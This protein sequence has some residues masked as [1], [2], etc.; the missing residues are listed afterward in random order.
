MDKIEALNAFWNSFDIPAIDEQSAYD[1][2]TLEQMQID[3][4]YITYE[5]AED[6]FDAPVAIG[7]DIWDKSTSWARVTR[8]AAQIGDALGRGGLIFP[9]E[10]G[11]IW[12]TR[13]S[14]FSQR[15]SAEND[16]NVRRIHINI[17]AEFLS[18]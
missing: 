11:A 15:L 8:I 18:A 12:I 7:G 5:V 10:G 16:D 17:N 14:P 2:P 6:G 3:Y 4:P 9:Y 1:K 13:G